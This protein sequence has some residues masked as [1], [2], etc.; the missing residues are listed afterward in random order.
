[1]IEGYL[2]QLAIKTAR[3][4]MIQLC[5]RNAIISQ[6]NLQILIELKETKTP[7]ILQ[8]LTKY[9]NYM[10]NQKSQLTHN[11]KKSA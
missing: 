5:H 7:K 10:E 6:L 1:M 8:I 3:I 11:M 4:F 9:M 2:N